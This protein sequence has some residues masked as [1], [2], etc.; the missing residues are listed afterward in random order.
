VGALAGR[1]TGFSP[2]AG[3]LIVLRREPAP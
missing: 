3:T 2:E 1:P